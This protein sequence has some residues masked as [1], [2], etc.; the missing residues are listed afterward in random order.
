[1]YKAK[2]PNVTSEY[3]TVLTFIL[4]A[5]IAE[6]KGAFLNILIFRYKSIIQLV[7]STLLLYRFHSVFVLFTLARQVLRVVGP[8]CCVCFDIEHI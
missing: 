5:G 2:T 1:M 7:Q 6:L 8:G 4:Y 3:W